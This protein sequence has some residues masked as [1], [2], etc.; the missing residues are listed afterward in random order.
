[1]KLGSQAIHWFSLCVAGKLKNRGVPGA[2]AYELHFISYLYTPWLP[3]ACEHPIW[4][5]PTASPKPDLIRLHFVIVNLWFLTHYL[6][7]RNLIEI[8]SL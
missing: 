7:N 8:V 6:S 4:V 1:M 5:Q 2:P 3:M